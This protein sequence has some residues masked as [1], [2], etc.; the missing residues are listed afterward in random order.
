WSDRGAA[1]MHGLGV[2][3]RN[4]AYESHQKKREADR[5]VSLT[6]NPAKAAGAKQAMYL[7]RRPLSRQNDHS[8]LR[9]R[10]HQAEQQ[11]QWAFTP[12]EPP[13]SPAA[14]HSGK[15]SSSRRAS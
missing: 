9:Q 4:R 2:S 8:R 12:V 5:H 6:S 15:P 13:G 10:S 11:R 1:E 3:R 14:F 7:G